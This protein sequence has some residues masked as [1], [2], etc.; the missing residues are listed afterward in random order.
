MV[1]VNRCSGCNRVYRRTREEGVVYGVVG[2]DGER[3]GCYG[4][5]E[6]IWLWL[7]GRG[8]TLLSVGGDLCP[9]WNQ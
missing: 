2:V 9:R 8:G 1:L 6:R 3:V 7:D 5:G 4:G